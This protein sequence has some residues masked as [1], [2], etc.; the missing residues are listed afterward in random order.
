MRCGEKMVM[1][2]T[3]QR[4]IIYDMLG[5]A[6]TGSISLEHIGTDVQ[7]LKSFVQDNE[8]M[9]YCGPDKVKKE[10]KPIGSQIKQSG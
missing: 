4:W 8:I 10:P 6:A 7:E 1:T 3:E 5:R 9:G 2:K